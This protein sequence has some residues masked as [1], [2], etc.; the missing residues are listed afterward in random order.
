MFLQDDRLNLFITSGAF[1]S[2]KPVLV[3]FHSPPPSNLADSQRRTLNSISNARGNNSSAEVVI[4]I[5]GLFL[6]LL[7]AFDGAND[8]KTLSCQL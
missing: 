1:Y 2:N 3:T 8:S 7:F 5:E 4:R 6:H